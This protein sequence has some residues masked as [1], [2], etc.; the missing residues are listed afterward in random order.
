M[1]RL[2][3][4]AVALGAIFVI[5]AA[6]V[7]VLVATGAIKS[8]FLPG[9]GDYPTNKAEGWFDRELTDLAN[10]TG[11]AEIISIVVPIVVGLVM[12]VVL[13]LE[14]RGLL[15]RREVLLPVSATEQGTLNVEASSVQLLAERT[16]SI[17]RNVTSL[18]CRLALMRGSPP[19][20][21]ARIV[22]ACRPLVVLGT[23]VQELRDDLQSRIK[24]VVE[25][26][27]GLHVERVDVR[28]VR[29]DRGEERRL[30]GQ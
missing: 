29:Y 20:G 28:R 12:L 30:L 2:N 27:T 13:A 9:G 6:V 4:L 23:N 5:V 25:Q 3:R 21:P 16:G 8:W 24:E 10:F 7:T 19:R 26:L 1:D 22:I 15:G 17:N 18:R 14:F 11:S